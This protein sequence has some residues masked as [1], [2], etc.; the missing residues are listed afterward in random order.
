MRL[1][2]GEKAMPVAICPLFSSGWASS[3]GGWM[4]RSGWPLA[5]GGEG[6]GAIGPQSGQQVDAAVGDGAGVVAVPV[7]HQHVAVWPD[8]RTKVM[9]ERNGLALAGEVAVE[10]VRQE[11]RELARLGGWARRGS[12]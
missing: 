1:P 7:G 11:M 9:R 12:P 5:V 2:S 3:P 6:H 8:L 10:R 4:K